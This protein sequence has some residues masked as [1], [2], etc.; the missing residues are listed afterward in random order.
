M[1]DTLTY[2]TCMVRATGGSTAR[3]VKNSVTIGIPSNT[4]TAMQLR[5]EACLGITHISTI[6]SFHKILWRR[7]GFG[8]MRR[9]TSR[10]LRTSRSGP[11]TSLRRILSANILANV[12]LTAM[13]S[14]IYSSPRAQ[15][16]GIRV[17]VE[18][19]GLFSTHHP[20]EKKT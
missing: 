9:L 10:Q 14:M 13:A 2:L 7:V 15:R 19:R 20:R 1:R 4:E 8:K 16:G 3:L 12:I 18:I 17:L 11:T 5:F 6:T